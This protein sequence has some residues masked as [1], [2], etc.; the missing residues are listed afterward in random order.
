MRSVS[1]KFFALL[2]VFLM[3][4]AMLA[5][6][7]GDGSSS[8]G[9]GSTGGSSQ[10][11]QGSSSQPD[12][13][14][15]PVEL[16]W[17]VISDPQPMAEQVMEYFNQ[18]LAEKT[19]LNVTVNLVQYGWGEY[20]DKLGMSLQTGETV[21]LF[22]T[23]SWWGPYASQASAGQLYPLDDLIAEYGQDI[24]AQL[25]AKYLE[26]MRIAPTNL[27]YGIPNYQ[28]Y[29]QPGGFT[30]RK[31][32]VDKYEF[33]YKNVKTLA[34]L[35]PFL[36][37]IKANEPGVTPFL[38]LSNSH[39]NA[40]RA[41][42]DVQPTDRDGITTFVSYDVAT[43]KAVYMFDDEENV[44]ESLRMLNDWYKKGYINADTATRN[45]SDETLTNNYAVMEL[46]AYY[47]DGLKTT[48]DYGYETYDIDCAPAKYLTASAMQ[49][50]AVAMGATCK[51]PERAMML[52]NAVWADK[53]LY[54][55]LC[56]GI[57]GETYN[58]IDADRTTIELTEANAGWTLYGGQAWMLGNAFNKYYTE[59]ENKAFMD[60][61][62]VYNDQT[63]PSPIM[64]FV[65]D[66][67][68]VTT[69]MATLDSIWAE[70][71]SILY[72]GTADP[73]TAL[74]ALRDRVM[75]AGLQKVL[76][77]AQAQLDAWKATQ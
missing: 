30:F 64:G 67:S 42:M 46:S 74:P 1:K 68:N 15:E 12:A 65:F 26:G 75:E 38:P 39:I 9:A 7:G 31:D 71:E 34:D 56:F 45:F 13:G 57:E 70:Q 53:D 14:L 6:C 41:S 60:A 55:I 73:A 50:G 25:D 62:E 10:T 18:Q 51:N 33:D 49:G 17:Y 54:N 61:Q 37:Q 59:V 20:L 16:N 22:Y 76:D 32:L 48:V 35:E 8:S 52:L 23:A 21:D 69:E 44:A 63:P 2:V 72:S 47:N 36:E 40:Y 3:L 27:I 4:V 43:G 19:D 58:F 77:E 24:T 5:A 29:V 28:G 66:Q 11:S